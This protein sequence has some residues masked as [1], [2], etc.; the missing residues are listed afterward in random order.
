MAD[1]SYEAA[2][3]LEEFIEE[4][5]QRTRRFEYRIEKLEK[6]LKEKEEELRQYKLNRKEQLL[7]E[8][9]DYRDRLE[10]EEQRSKVA[11]LFGPSEPFF[12][13]LDNRR[14]LEAH[15]KRLDELKTLER[16]TDRADSKLP[17][18][19]EKKNRRQL[20]SM[21]EQINAVD[22]PVKALKYEFKHNF[23]AGRAILQLLNRS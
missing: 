1:I 14:E 3:E 23:P 2:A 15:F 18:Q 4:G 8:E 11:R 20:S 13:C 7:K 10:Q 22:N 16:I 9:A 12:A 5:Q 19:H 21:Q 6:N 17:P